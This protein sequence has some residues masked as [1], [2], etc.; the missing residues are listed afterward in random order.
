MLTEIEKYTLLDALNEQV[1]DIVYTLEP[2]PFAMISIETLNLKLQ[3][4]PQARIDQLRSIAQTLVSAET[5]ANTEAISGKRRL[6]KADV[7]EW[8]DNPELSNARSHGELKDILTRKI[9][10]ILGMESIAAL[11]DQY[12]QNRSTQARLYR[13]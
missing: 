5:A 9:R 1:A 3:A 11:I 2:N 10:L 4:L 6:I 8:S 13:G 7:L 12:A